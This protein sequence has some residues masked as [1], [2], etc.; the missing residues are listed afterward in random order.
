LGDRTVVSIDI[1]LPHRHRFDIAGGGLAGG[2][3]VIRIFARAL[4]TESRVDRVTAAISA[5]IQTIGI[6]VLVITHA[7]ASPGYLAASLEEYRIDYRDINV[8]VLD[9]RVFK[10]AGKIRLQHC[11]FTSQAGVVG[12]IF[13]PPRNRNRRSAGVGI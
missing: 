9:Q 1:N 3:Y 6:V 7:I 11:S 4:G 5:I 10:I 2:A 12:S 13:K 8:Q